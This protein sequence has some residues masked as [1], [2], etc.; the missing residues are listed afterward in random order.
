ML[1]TKIEQQKK[2]PSRVS[3]FIDGEFAFGLK[4]EDAYL[5]RLNEGGELTRADYERIVTE[6]VLTSARDMAVKYLGYRM[7]SRR[8]IEKYLKQ[9]EFTDEVIEK[10]IETLKTYNYINDLEFAKAYISDSLR[11]NKWGMK[12]IKYE[13]TKR[14]V[15][16]EVID[17]AA[18]SAEY[19]TEKILAGLIE[20]KLN[21]NILNEA[22]YNEKRKLFN[23]LMNRGFSYD[24]I[25]AAYAEYIESGDE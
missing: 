17:E 6:T 19:S 10:T 16:R 8:E 23:Y 1:I 15:A 24:E 21:G 4:Y 9:K 5:Y 20:K 3:V 25:N 14:G 18:E 22:D 12:K 7:R 11:F 2:D 13:L